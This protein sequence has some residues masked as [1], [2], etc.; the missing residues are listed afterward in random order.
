MIHT[1]TVLQLHCFFT[2][3]LNKTQSIEEGSVTIS[4]PY[5]SQSVNKLK[6]LCRGNRPSTCRQQAVITSRNN[7]KYSTNDD[8]RARTFT[9]TISDLRLDDAGKYW[10]GVTKDFTDIYKEVKLN[11]RPGTIE[12]LLTSSI[13]IWSGSSKAPDWK[14]LRRVVKT[15]EKLIG[16]PFPSIQNI[17][18]RRC[19][20]RANQILSDSTHPLH[21]LFIQLASGKRFRSICCRTAVPALPGW[22]FAL[23]PPHLWAETGGQQ[24]HQMHTSSATDPPQPHLPLENQDYQGT[25]R[26]CSPTLKP[27]RA[28]QADQPPLHPGSR[29]GL[30]L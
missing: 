8:K 13:S 18:D 30:R 10:C 27:W 28:V 4:C 16:S 15:A 26:T 5:D 1:L 24:T 6:F 29:L 12:S 2:Q 17:A 9:V 19:L 3:R 7:N 14:S 11:I 25:L 23:C 21:H 22:V 20:A